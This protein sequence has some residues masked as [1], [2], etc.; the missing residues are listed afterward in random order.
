[1]QLTV[2]AGLH[3]LVPPIVCT[4]MLVSCTHLLGARFTAPYVALGIISALLCLIVIGNPQQHRHSIPS[5][6]LTIAGRVVA[7]WAIVVATLLL[8]GYATKTSEIFS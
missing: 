2:L 1:M 6:G 5:N 4:I 8:I 3:G 7:E